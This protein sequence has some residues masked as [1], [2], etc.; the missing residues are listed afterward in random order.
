GL[1]ALGRGGALV[2][3]ELRDQILGRT[4]AHGGGRAREASMHALVVP[5][6]LHAYELEQLR[7]DARATAVD[8]ADEP[9]RRLEQSGPARHREKQVVVL[10][11]VAVPAAQHAA[12]LLAQL[13]PPRLCDQTALVGHGILPGSPS[14]IQCPTGGAHRLGVPGSGRRRRGPPAAPRRWPAAS[15]R[16][17]AVPPSPCA[18]S[19]TAGTRRSWCAA[20]TST[21]QSGRRCAI[22]PMQR[23]WRSRGATAISTLRRTPTAG[24]PPRRGSFRAAT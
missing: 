17:A 23:S 3:R 12:K 14:G 10:V 13:F 22:S 7:L 11:G 4:P 5:G 19:T 2:A 6:E 1:R 8:V 21:R 15:R 16:R 24:S 9:P 20:K 18:S